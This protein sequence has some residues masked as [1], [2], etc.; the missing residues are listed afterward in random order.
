[1][2]VEVRTDDPDTRLAR[3]AVLATEPEAAGPLTVTGFRWHSGRLLL[4]LADVTDRA[5]AEALRGVALLAEGLPPEPDAYYDHELVG[6]AATLADG[7]P[8]GTVGDVL[9]LPG[10]ELLVVRT[11]A[12][13]EALV[14]FVAAIVTTVDLAARRVTIDPPEGLLD[15]D[16]DLG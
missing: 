14:P 3:G 12:G 16:L 8:L 6:L 9:H 13:R 11:P 1:V 4:R 5:A 15:L 7:R 2:V 10:H